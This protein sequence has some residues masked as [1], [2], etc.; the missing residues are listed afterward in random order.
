MH[1]L[2]YIPTTHQQK[3][4]N[5]KEK[6]LFS[7]LF[8]NCKLLPGIFRALKIRNE[9]QKAYPFKFQTHQ[10]KP[11]YTS[12]SKPIILITQYKIPH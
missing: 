12:K 9:Q 10:Q 3:N 11:E 7:S 5:R 1:E 4:Q 8:K 6:D 2:D